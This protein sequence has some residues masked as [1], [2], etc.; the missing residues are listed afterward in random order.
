MGKSNIFSLEWCLL[1]RCVLYFI[2][3][4]TKAAGIDVYLSLTF[5]VF[6]P[7]QEFALWTKK[8]LS[9]CN[10]RTFH[11]S[12]SSKESILSAHTRAADIHSHFFLLCGGDI[13]HWCCCCFSSGSSFGGCYLESTYD[14]LQFTTTSSHHFT[15][16]IIQ[17]LS[18]FSFF[19][20]AHTMHSLCTLQITCFTP[21][22]HLSKGTSRWIRFSGYWRWKKGTR[23]IQ[24][25]FMLIFTFI[26]RAGWPDEKYPFT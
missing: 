10:F 11:D 18:V 3:K 24:T 4:K 5:L 6:S 15:T 2:R 7:F 17:K 26:K 8:K 9:Q 19:S 16:N 23:I 14:V 25:S 22:D 1:I 13:I 20:T 12:H 21:T